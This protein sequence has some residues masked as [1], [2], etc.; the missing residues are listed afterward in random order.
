VDPQPGGKFTWFNGSV[1]G[2]FIELDKDSK[3][4]MDWKFS[5]WT[6]DCTSRV[7]ITLEAPEHGT[8]FLKLHQTG[9][10]HEDRFGQ[11]V[12]EQTEAGWKVQVLSRIRQVFGYGF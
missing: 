10:P 9:I 6:D 4:V 5:T 11:S 8:T 3:V 12:F 1:Q 2:Q 7:T